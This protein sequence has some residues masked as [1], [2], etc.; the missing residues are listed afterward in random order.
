[1]M[2]M[3]LEDFIREATYF[4]SICYNLENFPNKEDLKELE[5]VHIVKEAETFFPQ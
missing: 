1:M 2:G 5:L 4:P 3:T